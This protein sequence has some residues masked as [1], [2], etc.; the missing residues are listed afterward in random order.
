M[1]LVGGDQITPGPQA[2][3]LIV[4]LIETLLYYWVG[5]F[6]IVMFLEYRKVRVTMVGTT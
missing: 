2:G 5:C 4:T 6:K 1:V 3:A